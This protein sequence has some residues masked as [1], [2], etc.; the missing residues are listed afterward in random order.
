[1]TR[2]RLPDDPGPRPSITVESGP[3]EVVREAVLTGLRAFNRRHAEPPGFEPLVVSARDSSGAIIGGLVGLT[4]WT[5]LHVDLLWVDDG[6]RGT[7]VGTNLLRAAE[8]EAAS[9]G[10]RHVDLDTFD[11]QAK[12]FYTRE[13]YSVFGILEDYPPGHTR[14]FMRKDLPEPPAPGA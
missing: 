10:V 11:F 7:G 6:H 9:R 4:G 14:Y 8:Q 2:A 12:P 13:G 3:A 1:M 5:W